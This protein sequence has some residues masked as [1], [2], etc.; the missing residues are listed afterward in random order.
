MVL[1]SKITPYDPAWPLRFLA[2]KTLIASAF[3]EALISIHHVGSTSVPGL[4][5]KP[6]IDVLIEV[7]DHCNA[8]ARDEVLR[9]LGTVEERDLSDAPRHKR[10]IH[11]VCLRCVLLCQTRRGCNVQVLVI[12]PVNLAISNGTPAR[13]HLGDSSLLAICTARVSPKF[14][15]NHRGAERVAHFQGK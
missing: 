11:A 9:D 8:S 4:A 14:L 5:A 2:D 1:T 12:E 6:E 3:G 13:D 10:R 15:T 7:C